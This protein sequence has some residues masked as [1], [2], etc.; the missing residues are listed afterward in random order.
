VSL[1]WIA[2]CSSECPL[3]IEAKSPRPTAH[4]QHQNPCNKFL[5]CT[6]PATSAPIAERFSARAQSVRC[7]SM[8]IVVLRADCGPS[9]HLQSDLAV[10]QE[11]VILTSIASL[12]LQLTGCY[13]S[14]IGRLIER[15]FN[16]KKC[17]N[18]RLGRQHGFEQTH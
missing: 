7:C 16:L 3:S 6:T 10:R 5:C 4:T 18:I 14:I 17:C 13:I 1:V 11:A 9:L 2:E 15:H 8:H 12:S